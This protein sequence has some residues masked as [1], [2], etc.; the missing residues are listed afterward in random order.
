M[1]GKVFS[2]GSAVDLAPGATTATVQTLHLSKTS[3]GIETEVFMLK[4]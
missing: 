3:S 4:V 1:A 2:Q